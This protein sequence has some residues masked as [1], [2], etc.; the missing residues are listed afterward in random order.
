M[1]GHLL[2]HFQLAAVAQVLCD[3]SSAKGMA[4]NLG[5]YQCVISLAA[6]IR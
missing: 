5:T 1:V 4:T 2:C 6:I 3:A